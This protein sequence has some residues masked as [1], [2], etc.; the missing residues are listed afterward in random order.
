[1]RVE[2][3]P[4][5]SN[6]ELRECWFPV[7]SP[8]CWAPMTRLSMTTVGS[9]ISAR[10][11][12]ERRVHRRTYGQPCG[13]DQSER[14]AGRGARALPMA[15]AFPK[16]KVNCWPAVHKGDSAGTEKESLKDPGSATPCS[17]SK[18][19]LLATLGALEL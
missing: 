18:S 16:P 10:F 11:R 4:F 15:G 13:M 17:L 8:I 5:E 3:H 9:M 2:L 14:A 6:Q 7:P 19:K 12:S 1:M